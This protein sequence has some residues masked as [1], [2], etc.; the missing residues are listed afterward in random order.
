LLR[1]LEPLTS[2]SL[3]SLKAS[4]AYYGEMKRK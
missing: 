2:V 3:T 4:L 1:K